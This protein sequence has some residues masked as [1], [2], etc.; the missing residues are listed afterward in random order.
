MGSLSVMMQSVRVR[1]WRKPVVT[2]L[3]VTIGMMRKEGQEETRW[4]MGW[5]RSGRGRRGR[6]EKEEVVVV[7]EVEVVETVR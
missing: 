6:K 2:G 5:A 1:V 7:V 4:V 3:L